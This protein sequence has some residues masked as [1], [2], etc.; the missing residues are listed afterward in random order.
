M[1]ARLQHG[2]A[3]PSYLPPHPA[4]DSRRLPDDNNTASEA[5]ILSVLPQSVCRSFRVVRCTQTEGAGARQPP[6][7]AH[8]GGRV[9]ACP[10]PASQRA[11]L[12]NRPGSRPALPGIRSKA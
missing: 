4:K 6:A 9:V 11:C 2:C 5:S 7:Q 10:Q 12:K 1:V 3:G 8:F